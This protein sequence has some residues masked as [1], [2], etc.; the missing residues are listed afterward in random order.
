MN[1]GDMHKE[2]KIKDSSPALRK[3]YCYPSHPR[4]LLRLKE[5]KVIAE[6]RM[7]QNR[8]GDREIILF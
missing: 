5:T 3:K 2:P 7:R 4:I 8:L 6:K 1:D